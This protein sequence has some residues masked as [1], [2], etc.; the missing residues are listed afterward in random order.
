MSIARK[1][2]RRGGARTL[3]GQILFRGSAPDAECAAERGSLVSR[4]IEAMEYIGSDSAP[5]VWGMLTGKRAGYD[6]ERDGPSKMMRLVDD[7][8]AL[9]E[10]EDEIRE[11][12]KP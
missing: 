12:V 4:F 10:A 6:P 1:V 11:E 8:R 5:T 7:V 3:V 2:R 9:R